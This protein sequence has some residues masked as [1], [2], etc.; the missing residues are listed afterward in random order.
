MDQTFFVC[1]NLCCHDFC[2][3]VCGLDSYLSLGYPDL[4]FDRM[5]LG[6]FDSNILVFSNQGFN[7]RFSSR[8]WRWNWALSLLPVLVRYKNLKYRRPKPS[9]MRSLDF[10]NACFGYPRYGLNLRNTTAY[11][12]VSLPSHSAGL[13]RKC[14]IALTGSFDLVSHIRSSNKLHKSN[15]LSFYTCHV[16]WIYFFHGLFAR[17]LLVDSWILHFLWV[18]WTEN[19]RLGRLGIFN[20]WEGCIEP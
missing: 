13:F 8:N 12:L 5:N 10:R 11:T 9:L 1:W 17:K 6:F 14:Q 19:G 3:E 20:N 2:W 16:P 18:Q 4:N 7:I 15:I